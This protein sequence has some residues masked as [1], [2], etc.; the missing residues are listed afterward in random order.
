MLAGVRRRVRRAVGTGGDQSG[1]GSPVHRSDTEGGLEAR[2][3]VQGDL[4]EPRCR[5]VR[6]EDDDGLIIPAAGLVVAVG[7]DLTG[8]DVAGMGDNDGHGFLCQRRQ[9]VLQEFFDGKFED[10][11]RFRVELSGDCGGADCAV[12]L[13]RRAGYGD[14]QAEEG[15][16]HTDV[17]EIHG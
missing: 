8:E 13:S 16:R 5:V 6:P 15:E 3:G 4:P 9:G 12:V 10:G 7:A 2:A 14:P 1:N 11:R 17:R